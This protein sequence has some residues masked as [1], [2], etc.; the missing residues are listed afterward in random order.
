MGTEIEKENVKCKMISLKLTTEG[1]KEEKN[2]QRKLL[3]NDI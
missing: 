2:A 1:T 3:N